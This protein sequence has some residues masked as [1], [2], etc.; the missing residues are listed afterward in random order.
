MWL[1]HGDTLG[2]AGEGTAATSLL[3]SSQTLLA[4]DSALERDPG[5]LLLLHSES[6]SGS[7]SSALG[8]QLP[9]RLLLPLLHLGAL[10]YLQPAARGLL[11]E[12][13]PALCHGSNGQL[14]A[15]LSRWDG[16]SP[17]GHRGPDGQGCAQ[18][19]GL[20][21]QAQ[22]QVP[23]QKPLGGGCRS[24][25]ARSGRK[26]NV[27][28][29][30]SSFGAGAPR[31]SCVSRRMRALPELF[32]GLCPSGIRKLWDSMN[33]GENWYGVAV[34]GTV[35]L[36]QLPYGMRGEQ[37]VCVSPCADLGPSFLAEALLEQAMIGPSP[38]PLILSY[39]KYAI[40]SQVRTCWCCWGSPCSL[41]EV[42]QSNW[43]VGG[44]Q[45][46]QIR[47]LS[48]SWAGAGSGGLSACPGQG[49]FQ[50]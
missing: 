45:A 29:S 35:G 3:S 19:R 14:K 44:G 33:L 7:S 42:G 34:V 27:E 6:G 10:T 49:R 11:G 22:P 38:N 20:V 25:L 1:A 48:L 17:S 12:V 36:Y 26:G 4:Q 28:S 46:P 16:Q 50:K 5:S 41:S 32:T 23:G 18:C 21:P 37:C 31:E 43:G 40:S 13:L 24:L 30:S 15:W 2:W 8:R 47:H 39:L 9:T